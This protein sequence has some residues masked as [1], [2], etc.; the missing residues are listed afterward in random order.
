MRIDLLRRG[1]RWPIDTELPPAPSFIFLSRAAQ[2][3]S[4]AIWPTDS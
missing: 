1:M 2:R 3:P 4:V